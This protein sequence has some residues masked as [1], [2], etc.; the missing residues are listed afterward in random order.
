MTLTPIAICVVAIYQRRPAGRQGGPFRDR[1]VRR[2]C[3]ICFAALHHNA[4]GREL[5]VLSAM[6]E[7][8]LRVDDG[9]KPGHAS[10]ESQAAW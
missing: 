4:S 9:V 10:G 8:Q 2:H 6:V 1:V 3:G 7:V 5:M